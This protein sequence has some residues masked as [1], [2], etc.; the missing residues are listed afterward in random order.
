MRWTPPSGRRPLPHPAGSFGQSDTDWFTRGQDDVSAEIT[1]DP[2]GI[3]ERPYGLSELISQKHP[4]IWGV[5]S[6]PVIYEGGETAP[7]L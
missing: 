7:R 6:N 3:E 1:F 4:V 5:A 2:T